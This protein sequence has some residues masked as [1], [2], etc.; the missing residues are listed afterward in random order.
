MTTER[1][2]QEIDFIES[3]M[4]LG[5]GA[6]LLDVGCGFGRHSVELAARGYDAVGIDPS[7]AMITAAC[8]R[9][10]AAGVVVDFRQLYAEQFVAESPFDAA[11]CLF[12]SLGQ[13]TGQG[14]NSGLVNRVYAALK[15]GGMFVV[16]VP[17]QATAVRQL[18]PT[19]QYS[20]DSAYT[21]VTRR[22]DRINPPVIT[23]KFRVISKDTTTTYT[24]KYRLFNQEE[25]LS[26]LT[27]A[28]FIIQSVFGDYQGTP[29]AAG[30]PIMLAVGRKK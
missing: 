4:G 2:A 13:I 1:T 3:T 16:E 26:L 29:L 28:G 22:L 24:L 17:Q 15:P 8:E 11:I 21:A 7:A 18:K 30:H 14:E 23:E 9:A 27:Q 10:A 12:T 5:P 6:R 19:D 20:S 25:L